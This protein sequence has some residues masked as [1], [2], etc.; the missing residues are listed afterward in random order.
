MHRRQGVGG[1][2][3]L[4]QLNAV[5]H[6]LY[7][8]VG[9]ADKEQIAVRQPLGQ[10]TRAVDTF[11]IG[12]LQGVLTEG[13]RGFFRVFIV[14]QGKTGAPDAKLSDVAGGGHFLRTA[15]E[16]YAGIDKRLADGQNLVVGVGAVYNI[17]GAVA[18]DLRRT[19]EID[20]A[21][22]R[23][24]GAPVI[25]NLARKQFSGEHDLP[26]IQGLDRVEGPQRRQN[27]HGRRSPD[28]GVDPPFIQP[29]DEA[30]GHEKQGLFQHLDAG[31]VA[32]G[33][34]DILYR[35]VKV[36]GRLVAENGGGVKA[37]GRRKLFSHIDHASVRHQDTLGDAGGAGG[38]NAVEGVCVQPLG[39]GT[40]GQGIVR[41][42]RQIRHG[43]NGTLGKGEGNAFGGSQH[44][45]SRLHGV[46]NIPQALFR[47]GQV[48]RDI[49]IA[50]ARHAQK[51]NGDCRAAVNGH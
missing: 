50:A 33:N 25:E 37:E 41:L 49:E 4:S 47:Q 8:G 34:V 26:Q 40:V 16:E 12:A 5:T 45:G 30:L 21:G 42:V 43:K 32:Q 24:M 23:H 2:L 22:L 31:G 14:A 46:I 29:G 48:Q 3:D 7:L 15:A 9:P 10:V 1:D 39:D 36:K 44:N 51:S 13:L 18:G 35:H 19:V 27:L 20:V 28:Q 6:V 38:E 17:I 11:G